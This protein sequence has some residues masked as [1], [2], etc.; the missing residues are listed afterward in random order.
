MVL[1]V[2]LFQKGDLGGLDFTSKVIF[3]WIGDTAMPKSLIVVESPTKVKTIGKF[4]GQDYTVR[5]SGGHVRDL[6]EKKGIIIADTKFEFGYL[7]D[8]LIFIDEVLTPDSS[9]FWP[10][11][12][13]QQGGAQKSFDKQFLRDYLLDLKW[14]QKPPPPR[15]PQTIIEKTR[16]KYLE[17]LTRLTGRGLN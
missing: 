3:I 10:M 9:R 12:A 5:A 14:P 2:P 16:E 7:D 11:D 8:R 6:A 15:L 4:L 13:Y 17:A 1:K